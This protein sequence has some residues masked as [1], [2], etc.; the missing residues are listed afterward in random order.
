MVTR[1]PRYNPAQTRGVAYNSKNPRP[2]PNVPGHTKVLLIG[3][4]NK[5][6]CRQDLSFTD[7]LKAACCGCRKAYSET[8][9]REAADAGATPCRRC[10]N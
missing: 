8:T 4:L 2:L 9:A 5:V 3:P 10:F 1:D 6:Y 7:R